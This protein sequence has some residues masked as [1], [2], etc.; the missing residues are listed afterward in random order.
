MKKAPGHLEFSSIKK[1]G[2]M[3]GK[4]KFILPTILYSWRANQ[5]L[6]IP[7]CLGTYCKAIMVALT[8]CLQDYMRLLEPTGVRLVSFLRLLTRADRP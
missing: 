8:G 5:P 4:S 2:D 7:R 3:D 6:L 1:W